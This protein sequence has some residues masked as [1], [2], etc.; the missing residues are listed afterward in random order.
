MGGFVILDSRGV[1]FGQIALYWLVVL[2]LQHSA[3]CSDGFTWLDT[4]GTSSVNEPRWLH[5][6][7]I[8]SRTQRGVVA[9]VVIETERATG[10]NPAYLI[11]VNTV[12]LGRLSLAIPP[13]VGK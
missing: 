6:I 8:L 11:P 5:F 4:Y 13:R 10:S 2:N 9:Q 12:A 7:Y 3:C 1:V